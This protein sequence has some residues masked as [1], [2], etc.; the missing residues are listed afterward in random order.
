M[1]SPSSAN[2]GTNL[3]EVFVSNNIQLV[4]KNNTLLNELNKALSNSLLLP[5]HIVDKNFIAPSLASASQGQEEVVKGIKSYVHSNH[6]TYMDNYIEDLATLVQGYISFA[7]NVVNKEV[8]LLKEELQE[9]LNSYKYKEPEEFFNIKYFKLNDIY[10]SF[11]TTSEIATYADSSSKFFY[12]PM[13][14][15]S[16]RSE[17]F[18]LFR[19]LVI[20]EEEQ[21]RLIISWLSAVT[22]ERAIS[23]I[24]DKIPEY[25]LS[26]DQLLDYSLVNYLFFRNLTE[27]TDLS[28]GYTTATLVNKSSANRDYFGNK[29][30]VVLELYRKDIRN[31]R[32]LSS[33]SNTNFSY[34]NS[35][36]LDITVYEENLE[37]LAEAGLN[38][39]VLF[40]Y[41]SA[42][43]GD[44]DVSVQTLIDNAE[45]YISKWTNTRSLYLISLNNT[46]LDV[47]KQILRE[48]FEASLN[49]VS[50]N[51]DDAKFLQENSNYI[52]ETRK[53]GNAYIDQLHVSDI[54]NICKITLE[55]VANIR[56]RYTNAMFILKEMDEILKMDEKIEPMEAA[57]Y[58]TIKYITDYLVEQLDIVKI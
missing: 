57:L 2:I 46:R 4:P 20:G 50:G 56:Y 17:D 33:N 54:D 31:G 32:I 12:E 22:K 58:S 45:N 14:L 7:R 9:G 29:L 41:I 51:E 16:I 23:Y 11:I 53:L 10:N 49:R 1:L 3:A 47:F 19:Y 25:E 15:E 6:D 48:R 26:T 39:E 18:D 27:R 8:I 55:L 24:T 30:F 44:N 5:T 37:K 52:E 28:L 35:Q 13:T 43:L 38:I 36:A 40:G 21:D 34:F 42:G